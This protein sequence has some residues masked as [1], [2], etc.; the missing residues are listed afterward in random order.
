[1]DPSEYR[2]IFEHEDEHFWY[3]ALHRLARRELLRWIPREDGR[4]LDAGC[5]TGGFL[6]KVRGRAVGI[7]FSPIALSFAARRG[8]ARLARADVARLPF[9]E[10]SFDAV[11]SLDV[12]YH[13]AVGDDAAA[14][15]ECARVLAPGGIL[16]LNLPAHPELRSAHDAIIHTARRYTRD[17]VTG[18]AHAAGLEIVRVTGFNALLY[19]VAV[20]VRKLRRGGPA[21][22]DVERVHPVIGA[23]LSAILGIETWLGRVVD[24]PF[25]LSIFAV[26]RKPGAMAASRTV[27]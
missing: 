8:L 7:D 23:G 13:Q 24:W 22:S 6:A 2:R 25:G 17:A 21:K 27:G 20:G 14:V 18:L 3:R 19:P 16:V 5:G 11:V 9:A 26:F 15:K 4:V 1:M 12:L 10:A